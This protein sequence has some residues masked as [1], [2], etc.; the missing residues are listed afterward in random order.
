MTDHEVTDRAV[1]DRAVTDR[2]AT[3]RVARAEDIPGLVASSVGLFAE[4]AGTRDPAVNADWPREHAAGAFAT[5]LEDPSRLVLVV[6]HEGQ[7]VGHLMGSLTEPSALRPVKSATLMSLYVRP[8][9]RRDGAGGRLVEAFLAWA[10]EQ[11]AG[12]TEVTAYT[13]NTDALR[14][15]ARHGFAPRL[16]TLRRSF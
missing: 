9:H 13:D 12:Q 1:T 15:Y 6:E 7:V 14:F 16:V 10:A 5:A 8:A 2:A 4:D 11:G 3:V